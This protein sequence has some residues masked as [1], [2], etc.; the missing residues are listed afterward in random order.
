[1]LES[2]H[3]RPI[4]ASLVAR[5]EQ[6]VALTASGFVRLPGAL[7]EQRSSRAIVYA[8]LLAAAAERI[9]VRATPDKLIGWLLLQGDARGGYGSARATRAAVAALLALPASAPA[10]E[11]T[12]TAK[13]T[14]SPSTITIVEGG[15]ERPIEIGVTGQVTLALAPSTTE[16]VVRASGEPLLVR[17][18]RKKLRP[19]TR[20][21]APTAAPFQVELE[22]PSK[23]R[24]GASAPLRVTL[25][26]QLGRTANIDLR[27][28]LPAGARL[29]APLEGA[30]QVQG[31]LSLTRRLEE[32]DIPVVLDVPI[33]F[34]LTGRFTMPEA[35]ATLVD[36]EAE[37]VLA[38]ARPIVV[39]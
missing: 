19:W 14:R 33:R 17:L 38:P 8:A 2:P 28:P 32:S 24:A 37:R 22:W 36:E 31:V 9:P 12:G 10:S 34:G 13:K 15:I 23:L 39:E 3:R 4:A 16:L 30:R 7:A 29:A 6:A 20:L 35:H 27:L 5:L 25:R 18:E 11:G 26:N 1:L 21:P